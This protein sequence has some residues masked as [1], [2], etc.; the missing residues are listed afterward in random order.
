MVDA[1]K[2]QDSDGREDDEDDDGRHDDNSQCGHTV[3]WQ[4]ISCEGREK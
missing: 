4:L 1:S 2:H 3:I